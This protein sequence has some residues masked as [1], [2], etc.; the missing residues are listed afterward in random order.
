MRK[1]F[2]SMGWTLKELVFYLNQ[3]MASLSACPK[4]LSVVD[5]WRGRE[6]VGDP[7]SGVGEVAAPFNPKFGPTGLRSSHFTPKVRAIVL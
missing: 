2:A 5:T 7:P 1:D 3:P 6:G 4:T